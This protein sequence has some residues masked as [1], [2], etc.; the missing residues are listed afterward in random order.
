MI[1]EGHNGS[2]HNPG[3]KETGKTGD[4]NIRGA[5]QL[6]LAAGGVL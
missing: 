2:Q 3:A 5:F 1:T 4:C 6:A